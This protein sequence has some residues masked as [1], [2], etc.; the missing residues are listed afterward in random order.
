LLVHGADPDIGDISGDTPLHKAVK[1][2]TNIDNV[3]A[4]LGSGCSVNMQNRDGET[5]M[6]MFIHYASSFT[7]SHIGQILLDHSCDVNITDKKGRNALILLA[8]H[9]VELMEEEHCF[10]QVS[11][12]AC[13][14]FEQL[15]NRT[16]D[17]NLRDS[18]YNTALLIFGKAM[19]R[20]F[21]CDFFPLILQLLKH[22]ADIGLHNKEGQSFYS[23]FKKYTRGRNVHSKSV[24]DIYDILQVP[25]L[26]GLSIHA[27]YP[28]RNRI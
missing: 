2:D 27:M 19:I 9:I 21:Y 4:L 10:P 15:L 17:L 20:L 13:D 1:W 16:Y 6:H 24:Q 26:Q 18:N 8:Y 7:I 23:L 25:S 12:S 28:M 11:S 3:Q 22:G 14:Y 5:P